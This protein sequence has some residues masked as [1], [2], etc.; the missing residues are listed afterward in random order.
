MK[1]VAC[2]NYGPPEVLQIKEIK[3][4]I[5]KKNEVLVKIKN[6]SVNSGDCRVRGANFPPG[7]DIPAR[8]ILGIFKPRQK[9]LGSTFSGV[10]ESVGDEVTTLKKGDEVFGMSGVKMGAYAEYITIKE[11]SAIS[12]KPKNLSFEEAA[13]M[14]FGGSTAIYFLKD[15]ADIKEGQT[16]LINGASGAVGTAA[17]QIAKNLGAHV[18]GVCSTA[19]VELVK[20]LGADEV[21]D[22]KKED[23]FNLNNKYDVVVETVGNISIKKGKYLLKENGKLVLVVSSFADLLR[24][25]LLKHSVDGKRIQVLQGT[26]LEKKDYLTYLIELFNQNKFKVIIDKTFSLD[27]M[28][29]AHKYVETGHKAGNVVIN[30]I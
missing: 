29:E 13:A 1:A 30:V 12:I 27:E 24:A 11:K 28:A 7:F 2:P 10:I 21:I 5:P 20:S 25:S 4:P 17:I 14:L 26:A 16:V 22:Y 18:I 6:T 23:I 15:L 9:I 8:L 3:K 19:N